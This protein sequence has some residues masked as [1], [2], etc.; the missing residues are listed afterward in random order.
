[1]AVDKIVAL[2]EI[3]DRDDVA[4]AAST[5]GLHWQSLDE[6]IQRPSV[7]NYVRGVLPANSIVVVFGPPK[8]G[9]TFTIFDLL[10]HAAHGMEW[11]GCRVKRRL[12]VAYLCGEGVRGLR[13]RM[14][15]W[16][17]HHD[18]IEEPGQFIILPL[19]LSLPAR[20][21]GI[22]ESLREFAP[23]IVVTDTLNAYF[24]LGDENSTKDMTAFCDAVRMLREALTC[25]VVV[26]HH[27]GHGEQGRE[28]G[29]IVLRASADVLIQ[30][31]KSETDNKLVGFQ[32]VQARDIETM[33]SAIALRLDL[34]ETAWEDEDKEPITTCI[35]V[36]SDQ[37]VTLPGRGGKPLGGVQAT[38]LQCAQDLARLESKPAGSEV[39][40]HRLD[41]VAR[42]NA[43]LDKP[44]ARTSI[45]SAWPALQSRGLL[46]MVEPGSIRIRVRQ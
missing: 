24:G 8:G 22:I 9:K 38:L 6:F 4:P 15:A 1:M 16:R 12:K 29:S 21:V 35:V 2:Q 14:Q 37:P 19:A 27:T 20:A 40:L 25:T 30:V 26:I 44:L 33:E 32:V 5:D 3:F 11:H 43:G 45:G 7:S 36:G 28:R 10:M 41:I 17:E 18:N 42:A 31:A 39:I 46:H 23:D 13:V 34:H